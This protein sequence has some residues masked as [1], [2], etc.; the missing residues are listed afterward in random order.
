MI[1]YHGTPI[2][3]DTAWRALA[4]RHAMVSYA[5]NDQT[6]VAFELC[7]SVSL[8]NGAFSAWTAGTPFDIDGFGEWLERWYRHPAFDWYLIPDVIDGDHNANAQMR[9]HWFSVGGTKLWRHGV[10]VYH[11]HEPLEVLRDLANAFDRVA[12]G[13][14]GEYSIVGSPRWWH[15][16]AE[17]MPVVC[18]D[19]I[20]R[21]KLHGLRMLD[22]TV[23]S[24]LPLSSADSTN[25]AR[26]IGINSAWGGPYAP[27][28][29]LSRALVLMDR[30]EAHA[31]ASTWC[32][33]NGQ[34][35]NLGLFG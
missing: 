11:M 19:G 24:H 23:F 35:Q 33:T 22:P 21:V 20:P 5:H 3:G 34:Q 9:A 29:K 4:G 13:S 32:S 7:Q 26:N 2:T 10:P 6:A 12:L 25:V 15:R 8:D 31:S 1:H 16:M 30:I 14:S 18:D 27:A 17:I 28:N